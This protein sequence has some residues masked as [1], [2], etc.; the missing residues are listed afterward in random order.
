M[1]LKFLTPAFPLPPTN[2]F[3][4]RSWA[5]LRCLSAIGHTVDFIGFG[6]QSQADRFM[7]QIRKV[8]RHIQVVDHPSS[9]LSSSR[10]YLRRATGVFSGLPYAV[11]RFSSEPMRAKLREV[12]GNGKADAVLV[13]TPYPLVNCPD[14]QSVPIILY[15]HNVEHRIL[16]RY[17]SVEHNPAKL[18]YGWLELR[19]LKRWE[20]S[21][22]SRASLVLACSEVDQ[23]ALL[24]LGCPTRIAVAPNIVDVERYV[25][26]DEY[27]GATLLY[28]GGMDWLPNRDA[29]EFFVFK[30]MPR[31]RKLVAGVKF[32]VAGR[33]PTRAFREKFSALEDVHFTGTVSDMREVMARATVCVV[34]LRIG[35]GTRL[36]ILEAAAMGRPV[37]STQVGAEG[38]EF[39]HGSEILLA[40]DPGSFAEAVALLLGDKSMRQR[41]GRA[42]RVKVEKSYSFQRLCNS[43]RHA[44]A[45][46]SNHDR[47]SSLVSTL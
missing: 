15:T 16:Q 26:S 1:V 18:A 39:I 8:C 24:Q 23:S 29:V 22:F 12:L 45:A 43:I 38:L 21:A 30:I 25:H 31:I 14:P 11:R 35:S 3:S 32:V 13:D 5:L 34:P 28:C 40:D 33:E 7:P 46:V 37:V 19:K 4:M 42:A 17:L 44:L 20:M 41:M 6:E 10:D 27:D 47:T 9:S 36:K 2:G